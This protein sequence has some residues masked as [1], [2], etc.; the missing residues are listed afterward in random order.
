[1]KTEF[2]NRAFLP[3]VLP[4]AI[5]GGIT[6][7]VAAFAFI[8]L[9]VTREVALVLATLSAGAILLAISLAASQD[10]LD[11]TKKAVIGF[12]G[13]FPVIV[14]AVIAISQPVDA[15]LL[16]I[17]RQPHEVLPELFTT[18]VA[19]SSV[20]FEASKITLP[21]KSEVAVV[22]ENE[23]AGV[24][25]NWEM[26]TEANGE[27]LAEGRIITG[28]A[29]DDIIFETPEPGTYYFQCVV[30][31]NMNGEVIVEEGV[32]PATS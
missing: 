17:N 15:S 14:G 29:E 3:V 24:Q 31:K 8:L 10:K 9:Y 25:H 11:A 16:N 23:E 28:V 13:I 32:E 12:A 2:R 18:I 6:V 5:L 30:H 27:V 1:M 22:F 20:S 19:K 4:L 26:L 7:L 21:A